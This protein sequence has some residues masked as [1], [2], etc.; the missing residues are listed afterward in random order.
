MS[1][2]GKI[3]RSSMSFNL[4]FLA[5]I[6]QFTTIIP[7][8]IIDLLWLARLFFMFNFWLSHLFLFSLFVI[9]FFLLW[10]FKIKSPFLSIL[11]DFLKLNH[12][13]LVF[14]RYSLWFL[15]M[16]NCVQYFTSESFKNKLS[17]VHTGLHNMIPY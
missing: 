14:S 6:I 1:L 15:K 3:F 5:L 11:Y 8:T 9:V 7:N 12:H 16:S 13:F 10:F 17:L 2:V 4:S